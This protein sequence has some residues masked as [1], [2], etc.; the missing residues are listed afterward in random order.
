MIGFLG[1]NGI[2][3]KWRC[4]ISCE[5]NKLIKFQNYQ[6]CIFGKLFAKFNRIFRTFK[7]VWRNFSRQCS[8]KSAK[9]FRRIICQN[10]LKIR[11]TLPSFTI[12]AKLSRFYQISTIVNLS[13]FFLRIETFCKI[14]YSALQFDLKIG[15]NL[16]ANGS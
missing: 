6:L 15:F 11:K 9:L 1:K 2:W 10:S 13:E 14:F 4:L 16:D 12:F 7:K 3:W 8:I 5:I